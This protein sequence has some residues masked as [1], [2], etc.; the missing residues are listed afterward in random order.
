MTRCFSKYIKYV[1]YNVTLLLFSVPYWT[2]PKPC[3]SWSLSGSCK[4]KFRIALQ[5]CSFPDMYIYIYIE[6]GWFSSDVTI[7]IVSL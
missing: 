2:V 3:A 7:I 1:N 5:H 4:P 6:L